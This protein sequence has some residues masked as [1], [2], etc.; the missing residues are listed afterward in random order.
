LS[1]CAVNDAASASS[2]TDA[3]RSSASSVGTTVASSRSSVVMVIVPPSEATATLG[4]LMRPLLVDGADVR[5][6][7]SRITH[8]IKY[9]TRLARRKNFGQK[10]SPL[11]ST[12]VT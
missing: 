12:G 2:G 5:L 1:V 6:L 7:T 11:T 9:R 4:L 8:L 3:T 10:R